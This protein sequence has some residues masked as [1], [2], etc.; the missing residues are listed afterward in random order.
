MFHTARTQVGI[1]SKGPSV[2]NRGVQD[3]HATARAVRTLSPVK[4]RTPPPVAPGADI[5]I[6]TGGRPPTPS[7]PHDAVVVPEAA[8]HAAHDGTR[9]LVRRDRRLGRMARATGEGEARETVD[10][11]SPRRTESTRAAA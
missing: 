10:Y 2:L 1:P 4:P 8:G 11:S 9:L 7:G 6:G 5:G 3:G